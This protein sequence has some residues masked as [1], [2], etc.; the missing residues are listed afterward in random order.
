MIN[1]DDAKKLAEKEPINISIGI[2]K[3]HTLHK[4]IKY[5]IDPTGINH[6]IKIDGKVADV[7]LDGMIYE[8]QTKAFN[9]LRDKL[10]VFLDRHEVTIC[11]PVINNKIINKIN[12]DG[13]II[14]I[15]KSPKK[16]REISA[17]VEFYK[18][19]KF[20]VYDN[21]KFLIMVMDIEEYQKVVT[22]SYK[23]HHGRLKID[24]VPI[25]LV[26]TV[27]L[28]SVEDYKKILPKLP[29]TFTSNEFSKILKINKHSTSY[30]IQVLKFV[31]VIEVIKKDGKKHIYHLV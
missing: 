13:E 14:S 2:Q 25:K 1:L 20:L 3:E 9:N 5:M 24:Q 15:R 12:D 7:Y 10:N 29:E 6:E 11:Y 8:I 26:R 22:K 23:N 19:K 4:V 28:N 18:I 30:I 16:C 31:G 27:E 17:L 21:L